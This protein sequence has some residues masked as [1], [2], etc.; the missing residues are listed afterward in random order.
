ME[1]K[2]KKHEEPRPL[3]T[4][5]LVCLFCSGRT[6]IHVDQEQGL[7]ETLQWEC[8]E[9]QKEERAI[10]PGKGTVNTRNNHTS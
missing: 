9:C 4:T 8:F 1:E 2:T 6:T 3:R 5:E 7:P 10:T